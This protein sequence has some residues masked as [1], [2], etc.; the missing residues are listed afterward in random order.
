[1]LRHAVRQLAISAN[2]TSIAVVG[3]PVVGVPT[4]NYYLSILDIP[5][6]VF[7]SKSTPI[8]VGGDTYNGRKSFYN[9]PYVNGYGQADRHP[10][11]KV[12]CPVG[13]QNKFG[14]PIFDICHGEQLEAR[15]PRAWTPDT[16]RTLVRS[17]PPMENDKS[18][19]HLWQKSCKRCQRYWWH[20]PAY[21]N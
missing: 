20:H 10:T 14:R 1:M 7:H 11:C 6:F 15:A 2:L 3:V 8:V 21:C 13:S 4:Y 9:I 5:C 17:S 19:K 16:A 12:T 18:E